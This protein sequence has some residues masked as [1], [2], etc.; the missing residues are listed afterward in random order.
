MGWSTY[1]PCLDLIPSLAFLPLLGCILNGST[2]H[3]SLPR[4]VR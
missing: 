1:Q 4:F 2:L 3:L